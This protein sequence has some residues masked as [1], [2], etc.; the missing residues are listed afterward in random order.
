M[1]RIIA[2]RHYDILVKNI[3]GMDYLLCV[4]LPYLQHLT[5]QAHI[6]LIIYPEQLKKG[7]RNEKFT[8]DYTSR[9]M[10]DCRRVS[11]S[12]S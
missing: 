3:R 10:L 7:A 4:L 9:Y 6:L 5:Y 1:S 12:G 11:F 2:A 8:V